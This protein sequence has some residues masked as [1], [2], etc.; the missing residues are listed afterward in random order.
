M[1]RDELY[2]LSGELICWLGTPHDTIF[3][4]NLYDGLRILTRETVEKA[5]S[6]FNIRSLDKGSRSKTAASYH[7]RRLL[8]LAYT[9]GLVSD[10]ISAFQSLFKKASCGRVSIRPEC[11]KPVLHFVHKNIALRRFWQ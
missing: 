5:L 4:T 9:N 1:G 2:Y 3:L 11:I 8:R 10:M 6:D 7:S